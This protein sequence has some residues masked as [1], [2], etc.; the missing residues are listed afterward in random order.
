[1]HTEPINWHK[2]FVQQANWT[3][4]LR[5]YLYT[6]AKLNQAQRVLE[7]GC[8]TGVLLEELQKR[9]PLVFGLDIDHKRI[10]LT[11][12]KKNG[13]NLT[14]ADAIFLPYSGNTFNITLCH[15]L[16]LWVNDPSQVVNEMT[17]VTYPGGTVLALAEPDY[18]GRIDYP[19]ELI[20]LGKW[21][22]RSLKYQG[23]DPLIGRKLAK[24][25]QHAGLKNIKTGVLGGQ[26]TTGQISRDEWELEWR[27]FCEDLESIPKK[28]QKPSISKLK[29]IAWQA[30]QNGERILY[31]PTF[32]ASGKK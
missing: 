12:R 18:G 29:D 13:N 17:R 31:V 3:R 5:E 28:E 1:M 10:S 16:L 30:R 6:H 2:R 19:E 9:V 15:F 7:V 27:V 11:T 20:A 4:E 26:W 14:C 32:W 22:S 21:Q 25:F 8:G 24:I 23:A